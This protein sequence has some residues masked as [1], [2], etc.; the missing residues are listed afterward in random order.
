MIAGSAFGQTKPFPHGGGAP[1]GFIPTTVSSDDAQASYDSWKQNYL[2]TDCGN[3]QVRVEFNSPTGTTVS[4]GMGY[5][6]VLTAYFGD[7]TNFDGLWKFAQAHFNSNKLMGWHES[8]SAFTTND[9][10][11]GSATDGDTDIGF[12]LVVAADQWG[13]TYK[14]AATTY[15]QALKAHDY[16]T[17][18]K[19]GRNMATNGDWDT[20]C[21]AS[22]SSYWMPGYLR[23][24]HEFTGDAFWGKAADDAVALW[25]LN[26]N[27]KTGLIANEVNEDGTVG[28]SESY[29]DYN[30]CRVPWRAITDYLWYGTAGSKAV[31]NKI[32]GWANSVGISKLVDGYNTD[33]SATGQYTEQNPW[34]GGWATGTMSDTQALANSFSSNFKSIDND[35]G[36]YYG[37]S[38]RSLYLLTLTGNFWKPGTA[39]TGTTTGDAGAS[40][41]STSGSS[42]GSSGS[43]GSSSGSTASGSS[44]GSDVGM[45]SAASMTDDGGAPG[46]S[47]GSSGNGASSDSNG[48]SSSSGGCSVG[49]KRTAG[50]AGAAVVALLGLAWVGRR[51]R[52]AS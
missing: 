38:L 25:Q 35:E 46:A 27:S 4:E 1:N 8:C 2:K 5:G 13:A 36:G 49:G 16:T 12:A 32:T 50:G 14:Q 37:A 7:K 22:N 52:R 18:S 19:S 23:V 10:G 29:V 15:L 28:D 9:G 41:G 17:C 47:S 24:F 51:R 30:G 34:V 42:S 43:S 31:T 44:S 6:M 3:G 39:S 40:S 26:A 33:G 11:S 20:G 21:T 48:G 45:Q